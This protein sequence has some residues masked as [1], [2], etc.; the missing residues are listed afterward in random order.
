MSTETP[1]PTDV[2]EAAEDDGVIDVTA[3]IVVESPDPLAEL[4]QQAIEGIKKA[5]KR[6]LQKILAL[7]G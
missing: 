4:R 5:K 2:A 1:G 7:L 6:T 3:N